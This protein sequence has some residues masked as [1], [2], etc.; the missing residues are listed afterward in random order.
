MLWV[1]ATLQGCA[2]FSGKPPL[3]KQA[4][5]EHEGHPTA[6]TDFTALV[7][8]ADVIY[9]PSDR[10]ASGGRGEPAARLLEAMEREGTP[11]AIGWDVLDAPQQPLLDKL[12]AAMT[13]GARE[14]IL[15]QLV[16]S[17]SGRVREHCRAVLRDPRFATVCHLALRWPSA[18]AAKMESAERLSP[19]EERELPRGFTVPAAGAEAFAER[20]ARTGA[21]PSVVAAAYRSYVL[22]QQFAAE[23]IVA[24]FRALGASG[25]LV[26][27]VSRDDLAAGQGVPFYVAQKIRLRQ[28]VLDSENAARRPPTIVTQL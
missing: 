15:D 25:R 14:G 18:I 22:A 2:S 20:L 7:P 9:F 19:D 6:E 24:H 5:L 27:F 4:L 28:I 1:A 26:V 21:A 3:P 13:P 11:F 10:A 23:Q 17:G 12:P 8:L 16:I